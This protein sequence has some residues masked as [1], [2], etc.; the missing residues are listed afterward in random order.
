MSDDV[1]AL[2]RVFSRHGWRPGA[3]CPSRRCDSSHGRPYGALLCQA[4]N[5][6]I[7]H[8]SR[9]RLSASEPRG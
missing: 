1:E 7:H 2:V 5:P 8:A 9:S 4:Q 6:T 3:D